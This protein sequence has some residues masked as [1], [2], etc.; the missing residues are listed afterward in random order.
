MEG[1]GP[2]LIGKDWL[3]KVK[4]DWKKLFKIQADRKKN[5]GKV[6]E[7]KL[8][9]LI[10]HYSEVFKDGL[11]AFTGPKAQI[12]VDKD[13]PPKFCKARPV[14]SA[15]KRKIE[16]ELERLQKEGTIEAVQF[17]EW[18]ALI[19]PIMK[20]DE[21]IRIC[22]DYKTTINRVAKLD[23][24][25]TPKEK[26]LLASL[27]G[28]K[29]FT[30]LDLRQ[31]YLQLPLEDESKLY[32]T[33]NTRKGLFQYNRLPFGVSSAPGI[34]QRNMEKLSGLQNIS[35]VIVRVDDILVSST[36]D[37]DHLSNLE[38]VLKRLAEAGLRLKRS[39]CLCS[40]K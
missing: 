8:E 13:A 15:M 27:G 38:E 14:P 32:T 6:V 30:K 36:D 2:N 23:N 22:G 35:Y 20:P 7:V 21:S 12:L 5:Q 3:N 19:V 31:V 24:Y 10:S 18:A 16:A 25:P 11:G 37:E 39:V 17:S 1:S 40:L 29:T 33:I 34:F 26:D 28:G 9:K 4:L